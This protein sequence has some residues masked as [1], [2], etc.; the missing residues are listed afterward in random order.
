MHYWL[1]AHSRLSY[2]RENI[3]P[4][5]LNMINKQM[6]GRDMVARPHTTIWF[7]GPFTFVILTTTKLSFSRNILG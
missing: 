6:E 3:F 2:L 5:R 7:I 4:V 1:I